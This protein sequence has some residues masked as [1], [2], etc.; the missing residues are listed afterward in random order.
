MAELRWTL[1]GIGA[2]F[3]LGL[4]LW[5][6]YKRGRA[7]SSQP[8]S[9]AA[10]G[11]SMPARAGSGRAGSAWPAS[12]QAASAESAHAAD[13][14]LEDDDYDADGVGRVTTVAGRGAARDAAAAEIPTTDL[15]VVDI[16]AAQ[17]AARAAREPAYV[18]EETRSEFITQPIDVQ[19]AGM[20]GMRVESMAGAGDA[21]GRA[22]QWIAAAGVRN[23]RSEDLIVDWP[24]DDQRSIL[25]LRV[26]ARGSERLGG[27]SLRQSLL[28]EGF[29]FGKFDIFHL[30]LAD[31]RVV[32]SAA[33]LTKPGGFSLATIDAQTFLGLNLF[34][35]L[36][37]PLSGV[38]ALERLVAS[39]RL[40]AQRL[41]A[42]LLDTQGQ[43]LTEARLLEMRTRLA[44]SRAAGNSAASSRPAPQ[45][46]GAAQGGDSV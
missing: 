15:P 46:V 7:A 39:G 42:D 34:A 25:A 21:A 3:V 10:A 44:N 12:S 36:P 14:G 45:A 13:A 41:R 5:E 35:V 27:R 43:P 6:R 38:E 23:L 9:D 8:S 2:L 20:R 19:D 11:K 24:A 40:L 29:I 32:L 31:G 28:G 17:A 30:P 33:S 22:E 37:G 1:L 16:D 18:V 4:L 26:E